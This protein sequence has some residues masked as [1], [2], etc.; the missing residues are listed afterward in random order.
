MFRRS[1]SWKKINHEPSETTNSHCGRRRRRGILRRT[2]T[3][4]LRR[5]RN[6]AVR[7]R[8]VRFIRQLGVALLHG[9]RYFGREKACLTAKSGSTATLVSDPITRYASSCNAALPQKPPRRI[10]Y[11]PSV[12][13]ATGAGKKSG[14]YIR[15]G[16]SH[17]GVEY[18]YKLGDHLSTDEQ[19]RLRVKAAACRAREQHSRATYAE[20][21][22]T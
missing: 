20:V 11:V 22:A 13:P 6:P 17:I 18:T 5:C 15:L 14:C 9:R 10:R 2:G 3:A 16:R 4:S 1:W 21:R 12:L 8:S 7:S 19:F